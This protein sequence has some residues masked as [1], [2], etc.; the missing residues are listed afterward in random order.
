MPCEEENI[1]AFCCDEPA[2]LAYGACGGTPLVEEKDEDMLQPTLVKLGQTVESHRLLPSRWQ[3]LLMMFRRRRRLRLTG[4]SSLMSV[5]KI[6]YQRAEGLNEACNGFF[7][8]VVAGASA[9][10]PRRGF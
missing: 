6:L 7:A 8:W 1:C 5:V 10:V 3:D 9:R 2:M 4:V